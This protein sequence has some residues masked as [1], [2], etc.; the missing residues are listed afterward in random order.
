MDHYLAA[1]K[2]YAVFSG[3]SHRAEYWTFTLGNFFILM[4]IAML[5]QSDYP[6]IKALAFIFMIA[7]IIPS[8][9]VSVRRLHD[10][11]RSGWW[12]LLQLIPLVGW[13]PIFIF[14]LFDSQPGDNTYGRNPKGISAPAPTTPLSPPPAQ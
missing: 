4:I 10:T 9:A 5:G 2:K 14:A 8:I 3:R 7:E 1:W 11:G 6:A 13:I 12:I